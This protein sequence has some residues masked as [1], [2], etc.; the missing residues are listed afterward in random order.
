MSRWPQFACL[1]VFLA[2]VSLPASQDGRGTSLA[3]ALDVRAERLLTAPVSADWLSYNGD[4]TG[5][6]FSA[7]REITA[8]N[9]A[10]LRAQ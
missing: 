5:R 10:Q 2:G 3:V 7:L 6:R 1:A 8:A 4:Y 9:V